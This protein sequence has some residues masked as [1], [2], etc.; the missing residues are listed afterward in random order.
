MPPPDLPFK[1]YGVDFSA[2]KRDAGRNTWVAKCQ[3]EERAEKDDR[4]V[5]EALADAAAFLECD[6]GRDS[7]LKALVD[8]IEDDLDEPRAFGLDFPFGLPGA[9]LDGAD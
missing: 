4:L 6:P 5:I 9:L 3:I 2:A 7:T 8:R 1:I